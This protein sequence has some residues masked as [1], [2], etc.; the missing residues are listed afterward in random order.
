MC[1]DAKSGS[2]VGMGM[3]I[4]GSLFS[5]IMAKRQADAASQYYNFLKEE[6]LRKAK[7]AV[8]EI[9]RQGGLAVSAV[10]QKSKEVLASQRAELAARG[11]GLDSVTVD[12]LMRDSVGKAK[13]DELAI[14]YNAD[15]KAYE[16]MDNAQA[17]AAGY[18]AASENYGK[19]GQM[20]L[21]NGLF[22]AGGAFADSWGK[23]SQTSMGQKSSTNIPVAAPTGST[24]FPTMWDG[25]SA[26]ERF[27]VD[28]PYK[29]NW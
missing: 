17:Q 2:G 10:Q 6:T 27:I 4:G 26:R 8:N 9:G 24:R 15:Y 28:N 7:F 23:W 5:A 29:I 16:T 21:I 19:Q 25:L 12:D 1:V 20:A 11:I 18:Q 14:Q 3:Q 22:S 13:L